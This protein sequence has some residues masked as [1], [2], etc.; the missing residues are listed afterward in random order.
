[1]LVKICGM[2]D[3]DNIRAV[4]ALNPDWMGFILWPGSKRYVPQPPPY[5]PVHARR[6]GVFVDAGLDEIIRQVKIFGL[7][8]IQLHGSESADLCL[9][10]KEATRKPVIKAFC[11]STPLD[12]EGLTPYLPTASRQPADY[13][14]FDTRSPLPGGSGHQFDWSILKSY[15]GPVPFLLSGGIGPDDLPRLLDFRHEYCIGYDLNSRFETA[16]ALKSTSLL[17]PFLYALRTATHSQNQ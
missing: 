5:L 7:D 17:G 16:P 11:L 14:L 3:P 15:H 9:A 4:E 1:M 10:V 2:R 6:V 12:L 13:F 8:I